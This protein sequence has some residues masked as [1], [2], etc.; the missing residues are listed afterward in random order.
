MGLDWVEDALL[1]RRGEVEG[2]G[3][4]ALRGGGGWW[5]GA[6][7]VVRNRKGER[8]KGVV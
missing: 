6:C 4:G 3:A 8:G 7:C 2:I 1:E 5:V